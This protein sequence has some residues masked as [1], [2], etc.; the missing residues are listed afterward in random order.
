MGLIV[1]RQTA[2]HLTVNS[3]KKAV[4][5]IRQT[6]SRPLKS[7][8]FRRS[9]RT[10]GSQ[11]IILTGT[12]SFHVPNDIYFAAFFTTDDATDFHLEIVTDT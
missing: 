7:D 11:R 6:V 1:S 9:S 5:V 12:T 4:I 2:K 8:Y 10:A 3:V